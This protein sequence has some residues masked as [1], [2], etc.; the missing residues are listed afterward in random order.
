MKNNLSAD[1]AGLKFK[2]NLEEKDESEFLEKGGGN[3]EQSEEGI[4][5]AIIEDKTT[6]EELLKMWEVK[7]SGLRKDSEGFLTKIGRKINERMVNKALVLAG[8]L[9]FCRLSNALVSSSLPQARARPIMVEKIGR[10]SFE[11]K[12]YFTLELKAKEDNLKLKNNIALYKALGHKFEIE[13][14]ISANI[15]FQNEETEEEIFNKLSKSILGGKELIVNSIISEDVLDYLDMDS[16][17]YFS[18]EIMPLEKNIKISPFSLEI[19]NINNDFLIILK[20]W[21]DLQNPFLYYKA[22]KT[23]KL[24]QAV[25]EIKII[26]KEGFEKMENLQHSLDEINPKTLNESDVFIRAIKTKKLNEEQKE[27]II[28][29]SNN[30][31]AVSVKLAFEGRPAEEEIDLTLNSEDFKKIEYPLNINGQ[32]EEIKFEKYSLS[33]SEKPSFSSR[34]DKFGNYITKYIAQNN[35]DKSKIDKTI[36]IWPP[37]KFKKNKD[38]KE[39]VE[40]LNIETEFLGA[41]ELKDLFFAR[42]EKP[43]FFLGSNNEYGVYGNLNH[44][45]K[46]K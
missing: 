2:E 35:Y 8:L 15:E 28:N 12:L 43:I 45:E 40:P 9:Y 13:S 30:F 18:A 14:G 41:G 31:D 17:R 21:L 22:V 26:L 39:F 44:N 36:T 20:N 29:L 24:D 25:Q 38:S 32:I 16:K 11:E 33:S 4:S 10:S 7:E 6:E 1:K 3:E 5:D 23:D 46:K 19:K 34:F 42:E 27:A 37:I